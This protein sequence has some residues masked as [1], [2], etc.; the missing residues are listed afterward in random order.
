[1]GQNITIKNKTTMNLGAA[2]D[3]ATI[4]LWVL[5]LKLLGKF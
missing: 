4:A 1:M 3:A 5:A 2:Q